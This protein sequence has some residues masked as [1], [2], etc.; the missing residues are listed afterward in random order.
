MSL[1]GH[2][3]WSKIKRQ[4]SV[5]DA[6]RGSAFQVLVR[7]IMLAAKNG[8]GNIDTNASLRLAVTKAK[9][10]SLP[11]D[12]IKKAI[13]KATGNVVGVKYEELL[14]EARGSDNL[15]LMIFVLTDNK[16]RIVANLRNILNKANGSL[17]ANGSVSW[18]FVSKG[19]LTFKRSKDDEALLE[20]ALESCD[21]IEDII[22]DKDYIQLRCLESDYENL[23]NLVE[24]NGQ[25]EPYEHSIEK[26]AKEPLV[27]GEEQAAK[28]YD[29]IDKLND[30]E[31]VSAVYSNLQY[32]LI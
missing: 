7:N 21:I 3:K 29:L 32:K 17:C 11:A 19:L 26:I 1:A 20:F 28:A 15:A 13:D 5:T 9:E 8:G 27:L 14:Y 6:K 16:N 2:N 30:I 24:V 4:K 12:N 22:E 18:N 31:D 23:L 25:F 10:A